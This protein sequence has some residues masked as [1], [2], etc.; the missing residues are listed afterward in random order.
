MTLLHFN[1]VYVFFFSKKINSLEEEKKE[2]IFSLYLVW[3]CVKKKIYIF[4]CGDLIWW[5][6]VYSLWM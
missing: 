1:D 6:K 4:E 2:P 5:K 3:W